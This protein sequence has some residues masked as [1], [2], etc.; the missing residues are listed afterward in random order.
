MNRRKTYSK[1]AEYY[2]DIITDFYKRYPQHRGVRAMF[3]LRQL[4]DG[5][6]VTLEELHEGAER[7][8]LIP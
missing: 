1:P 4:Y 7:G 5:A 3:V 2:T 8:V 6:D